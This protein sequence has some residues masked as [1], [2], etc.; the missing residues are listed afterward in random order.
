MPAM[1]RRVKV[2][3][4]AAAAMFGLLIFAAAIVLIGGNTAPGRRAIAALVPRLSGGAVTIEGLGGRFPD[5]LRIAKVTLHDRAGAFADLTQVQLDWSPWK[6]LLGDVAVAKLT[7]ARATLARLPARD[8]RAG[9]AGPSLPRLSISDLDIARLVLAPPVAG[10]PAS[11]RIQGHL[12]LTSLRQGSAALKIARLDAPG[13]YDLRVALTPVTIAATVT[14]EETGRGLIGGLA[15][16]PDIGPL[17]VHAT[18]A[19]PWTAARTEIALAAGPLTAKASGTADLDARSVNLDLSGAA[20]AMA[21]RP[22]LAWHRARFDAH[23]TG[24][25]AR[26][27]TTAH[28]AITGLSAAG[29]AVR[30]LRAE[31]TGAGGVVDLKAALSGL[32]VPG[33][34]PAL[35]AAAP[36]TIT[37]TAM[38]Q[39]PNRPVTFTLAHPLLTA[40]GEA[41]TVG[42]VKGNIAV[43]FLSLAPLSALTTLDLKGSGTL[44]ARFQAQGG[45]V[46]ITAEGGAKIIGGAPRATGLLGPDTSFSLSGQVRAG[47]IAIDHATLDG[48][49]LAASLQGTR[50][51]GVLDFAYEL[52]LPD[53]S[54][55]AP[56]L[57]GAL[58]TTGTISGPETGFALTGESR[59]TLGATGIAKGPV[60]IS[61]KAEGLPAAPSARVEVTGRLAG[62]PLR[63]QAEIARGAEGRIRLAIRHA[64]WKSATAEGQ[65]VLA[66]QGAAPTGAIRIHVARLK[67]IAPFVGTT[68]GGSLDATLATTTAARRPALRI[69]AE[70]R[71]VSVAGKDIAR[72]TLDGRIDDPLAKPVLALQLNL[73][74]IAVGGLA[75]RAKITAD[76][77][78]D[79][80]A[81]RLAADTEA[82]RGPAR[83][84]ATATLRLVQRR[85][86]VGTLSASYG[87]ASARLLSPAAVDFRDGVTLAELRLGIG[88][89]T[90]TA[91]GRLSPTLDFQLAGRDLDPALA[92]L[93]LP[94]LV[95]EGRFRIDARLN[96]AWTAPSGTVEVIG[97]ALRFHDGAGSALPP[98]E[99]K[100]TARLAGGASALDATLNAGS[101]IK[102]EVKGSL[103]LRTDGAL[104]LT[105]R[106]TVDLA[107][108]N[109]VL[110]ANGRTLRGKLALD[111]HIAGTLGAPRAS[112]TA[113]ISDGTFR[114][115]VQGVRVTDITG[116]I[117]AE[118]DTLRIVRL[119]GKAPPGTISITG[120][121]KLAPG[122]PLDLALTFNNAA[123]IT[124]DI[125]TAN[126]DAAL[127]VRGRALRRLDVSG[128]VHINRAE[129]NIPDSYPTSV[130]E[131]DVQNV[132]A[133]PAVP[134][135]PWLV[136]LDLTIDAPGQIFVRGRGLSAEMAGRITVKGTSQT[137]E[138]AGGFTLR[139]G[140]FS[141]AGQTL[142]LTSGRITFAGRSLAGR[143]NPE[144]AF[145]AQT[146]A[147]NVTAMVTLAGYADA[148]Q[149][150]LTSSPSMP[151]GEILSQ[152]LFG[153][154]TAH[155]SPFQAAQVAQALASLTGVAGGLDPLAMLR[156]GLGLDRLSVAAGATP[157][158]GPTIEAGK[159]IT[160]NIYVGAK[161]GKFGTTQAEVEI[162]LT[163]NLK[164]STTVAAGGGTPVTGA[165]PENDPG[166]SIGLT[167]QFEY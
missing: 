70:A 31:I 118:G 58:E 77:P 114:D 80:L 87:R 123:P 111:G 125:L 110:A 149:L 158:S 44:D 29:G 6:L 162:D 24:P 130:A 35:F 79:R 147:N 129:V 56:N 127:K 160:R 81:L 45:A 94:A 59:G 135:A 36:L 107:L 26:P 12:G 3:A 133:A 144:I 112:G 156:K 97:R 82:K 150:S 65:I 137:P 57:T 50:R 145:T 23:V 37:A 74:G 128:Q 108:F 28:L 148:P 95:A 16:L 64:S 105:S 93:F 157:T 134:R 142:T 42:A 104:D 154:D 75:A 102:L 116:L 98:A 143:L 47:G 132:G 86:E 164:L 22:G 21:P 146:T 18:L 66:A 15:G 84:A 41:D 117:R 78:L 165:T 27:D 119:T 69:T 43:R 61:L 7:V 109:A 63:L 100:A 126:M 163:K 115:Y 121:L 40:A 4:R 38:L 140:Q 9:T 32:R 25:M 17:T 55:L 76:G 34:K 83:L 8:A 159:Y 30:N 60:Q 155:L 53:L 19:G 91:A 14:V 103:P 120:S 62:A 151:Q 71:Q 141:I 68:V 51:N 20:P 131:L 166:S 2:L 167:Y 54:Q 152:L 96:G 1:T 85:L 138:I 92:R 33:P 10:I 72:L 5:R 99:F 106:G 139:R 73:D 101:A 11:L 90:L 113:E 39:K 89:A 124:T 13:T 136:G 52:A 48:R 67:D 161:Q 49:A 122:L 88:K 153:Q 46:R